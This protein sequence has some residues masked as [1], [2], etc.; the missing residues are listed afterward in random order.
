MNAV[1]VLIV[2]GVAVIGGGLL[3]AVFDDVLDTYISP[4]IYDTNDPYY[5][6]SQ[7]IIDIIPY[8]II[9]LGS[10]LLFVGAKRYKAEVGGG[11]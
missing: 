8:A 1:I 5:V 3:Y 2:V 7:L 6:G 4:F 11:G 10:I 9:V